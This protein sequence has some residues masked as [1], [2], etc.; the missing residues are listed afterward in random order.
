MFIPRIL[1]S[2]ALLALSA[3]AQTACN[4]HAEYCTL[5]YPN[6]T[7]IGAHDSPFVGPLP[8]HNQNL[9]VSEQLD[10]GI[11][12]L[13]GQTRQNLDGELSL[14]H[15]D[16]LLEDAGTVQDYLSTVK[17]WMDDHTDEVI[18]LL[19]TNSDG[20]AIT[21]FD[22]AFNGSGITEYAFVPSTSPDT[23][24]INSWPTFE[25]LISDGTRLITFL[26]W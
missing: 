17:A 5:P 21:D 1:I 16:C 13:Q 6:V 22:A 14:C 12:F 11:R 19:L 23:L 3:T 24:S 10:L 15:T 8:Q 25:E 4:G 18:T 26:G 2:S 20:F 7:Q 9:E